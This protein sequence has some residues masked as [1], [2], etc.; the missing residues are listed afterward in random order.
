VARVTNLRRNTDISNLRVRF[1]IDGANHDVTAQDLPAASITEVEYKHTFTSQGVHSVRV[2]ADPFEVISDADRS[3]NGATGTL[4]V[5]DRTP[6]GTYELGGTVYRPDGVTPVPGASVRLTVTPT[7]YSFTV[8]ADLDGT[9]NASLAD[10]RYSDGDEVVLNASD[11]RDFAEEVRRVYSEDGGATVDLVL[12]EGIHYDVAFLV[13]SETV[14]VNTGESMRVN[15][16]LVSVGTRAAVVDLSVHSAGWSPGLEHANGTAATVIDLPL[17]GTVDLVLTFQ[18]PTDAE[19]ATNMTFRL[20]GV[21]RE[22]ADATGELNVTATVITV[23]GLTIGVTTTPTGPAHDGETRYYNLTVSTGGNVDD[24]IDLTYDQNYEA[25]GVTFDLPTVN[26]PAFGQ[27][28]VKVTLTVPEDTDAGEYTISVSGASRADDTI[29]ANAYLIETVESKRYGVSILPTFGDKVTGKPNQTVQWELRVTNLGNVEDSYTLSIFGQGAGFVHRF[30]MDQLAVTEMQLAAGASDTVILEVDIPSEFAATPLTTMPITV[31]ASSTSESTAYNNT[32]VTLELAGILDLTMDVTVNTNSPI[33]GEKVKFTVEV[34]N[35]GPDDAE[36]VWVFAWF[37]DEK[38]KKSVGEI[39][40][41]GTKEVVIEWFPEK[42]GPIQV[43]IVLNPEGEDSSI[44]ETSREGD[45]Y[46][47]SFR[48]ESAD[49]AGILGNVFLWIALI[50]IVVVVIAAISM[51]GR[52][53]DEEY[54]EEYAEEVEAVDDEDLDEDEFDDEDDFDD[55]DEL[56]EVED[57]T[58]DLEEP[59]PVR[60]VKR[61]PKKR[62]AAPRKKPSREAAGDEEEPEMP[63]LGGRM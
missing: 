42:E 3:N 11:G 27:V 24:V 62:K 44:F 1:T 55:Y 57:D 56:G 28:V 14:M 54:A 9:Y 43:R 51:Y 35:L 13:A 18:V 60:E 15:V 50:I 29:V 22:D 59:E 36:G 47:K 17:D 6:V 8:T 26:L 12:Y 10:S 45:T 23:R 37:G 34:R 33:V 5:K 32:I 39:A 31:K 52:R 16:T 41:D 21:P 58:E 40:D 19:G 61:R 20:L 49:K 53:E 38:V 25:W 4:Q 63:M 7:A 2:V 30:E 48:V 46:V